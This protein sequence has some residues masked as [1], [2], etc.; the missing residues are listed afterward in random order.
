[1]TSAE[2]RELQ[3]RLTRAGFDTQGIDGRIG[4]DTIAAIRNWQRANGHVPDG[5]AS[6][7][8]LRTLR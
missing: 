1:M 3:E 4:P 6:I 5:Y 7:D 8:I 2:R